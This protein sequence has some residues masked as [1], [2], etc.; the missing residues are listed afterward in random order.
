ML[1]TRVITPLVLIASYCVL[2]VAAPATRPTPYAEGRQGKGELRFVNGVPVLF[3]EGSPEDIGAQVGLLTRKPLQR[4][5]G[6]SRQFLD[7]CGLGSAWPALVKMSNSMLPQFPADH[8]RELDALVKAT[9]LD[10]DLAVVGNTLP[11]IKKIAGCSTV[12]IEPTRSATGGPLFGR[13]LDYPTLGFLQ[14]YTVVT[15]YR[16]KGKHAFASVGFP[17]LIGCVSGMN[18]AGLALAVLEVYSSKDRATVFDPKGTPYALGYR[19]ILE[20]CTTVAEAEKL[21]RSIR[22]TTYNNLAI[23]DKEGGAVFEITPKSVVVRRSEQGVCPCTNHFCTPELCTG[24]RCRRFATLCRCRDLKTV[25]VAAVARKLDAVNQGDLTLQTMVFEPA[26]LKLHLAIGPCP[27]SRL[28]LK[29][30]DLRPL[31]KGKRG[32]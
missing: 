13:N 1:R 10:H 18:D 7:R 23:C 29:E 15:I 19:R 11:D 24:V 21:L 6:F 16:P 32:R 25:D 2:L 14:D 3:V 5:L 30:L 28:P 4:L 8:R 20:E 31:F 17:G 27:T 22:R 26:A 12:I 9:G